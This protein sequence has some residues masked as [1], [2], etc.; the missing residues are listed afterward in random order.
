MHCSFEGV[1]DD[2]FFPGRCAEVVAFGKSVG[3][4]GVL[5]PDTLAKFDLALPVAAVEINLQHFL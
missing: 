2:T 3:K 5:H 1:D 4:L